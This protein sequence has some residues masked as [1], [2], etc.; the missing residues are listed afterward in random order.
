MDRLCYDPSE[1]EGCM[2]NSSTTGT[3]IRRQREALQLTQAEL[4]QRIMVSDKTISK[5]ETGKGLPDVTLL[6]P[7]AAALNISVQEPFI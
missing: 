7:L 6:E 4:A 3:V 1:S 5:W 2:M